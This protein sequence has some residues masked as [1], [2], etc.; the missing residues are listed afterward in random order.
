MK[1][2]IWY[3]VRIPNPSEQ[4]SSSEGSKTSEIF[5]FP[6]PIN[7]GDTVY[8]DTTSPNRKESEMPR[9]LYLNV[10]VKSIFHKIDEHGKYTELNASDE[11]SDQRDLESKLDIAEGVFAALNK[12]WR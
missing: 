3:S 5:E 12:L 11:A 9:Q 2:R 4:L 1:Y 6:N 10:H 7:A 8:I